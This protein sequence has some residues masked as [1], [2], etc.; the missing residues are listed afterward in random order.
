MGQDLQPGSWLRA[1]VYLPE[2]FAA[3]LWQE[4]SPG[5]GKEEKA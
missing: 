1:F 3:T 5:K 2:V 4:M